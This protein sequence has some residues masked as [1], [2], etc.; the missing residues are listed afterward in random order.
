MVCLTAA[1][2]EQLKMVP[3][4]KDE[5]LTMRIA[6]GNLIQ[7]KHMVIKSV[8]V[9]Q[10]TVTD[11]DCAVLPKDLVSAEALL[12]GTF[13]NNFIFKIDPKAGEMHLSVI[14]GNPKVTTITRYEGPEETQSHWCAAHS[15]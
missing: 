14:A 9:G 5:T 12:G 7:A 1:L 15:K 2:A 3:S 6:D 8:R 13:L 4:D 10:F 11:V